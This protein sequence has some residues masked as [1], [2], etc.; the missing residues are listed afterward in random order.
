MEISLTPRARRMA[1]MF[2]WRAFLPILSAF[3]ATISTGTWC[4]TSHW[5]ISM[6]EAMGSWRMSMSWQTNCRFGE[7]SRYSSM[8]FF[9]ILRRSLPVLA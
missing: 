1:A 2:F 5:N 4:S 7:V 6:S 9:Q 8:N 3:V